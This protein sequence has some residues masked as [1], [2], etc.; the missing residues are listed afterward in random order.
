MDHVTYRIIEQWPE[1]RVGSDGSIWSRWTKG[2]G[3][4]PS[5]DWHILKPTVDKDGYRR[6]SLHGLGGNRTRKVSVLVCE[7]FNGPSTGLVCRHLNGCSIDDR[8]GNLIWGT[9]LENTEDRRRHGTIACGKR[10]GRTKLTEVEIADIL[11]LK[12]SQTQKEVALSFG[13]SRGYVG[14]LWSGSRKRV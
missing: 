14:Q 6:V 12:G 7:A 9:T 11:K 4:S 1:Y 5:H 8:I 13:I 3:A 2:P 10:H